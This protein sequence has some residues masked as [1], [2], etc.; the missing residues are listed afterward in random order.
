MANLQAVRKFFVFVL[1]GI[2]IIVV[3]VFMI[4]TIIKL[5]DRKGSKNPKS[6]DQKTAD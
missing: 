4:G 5:W 1:A 2:S 3:G 6:S